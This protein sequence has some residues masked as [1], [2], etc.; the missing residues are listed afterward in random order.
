MIIVNG[1]YVSKIVCDEIKSQQELST[2]KTLHVDRDVSCF[3]RELIT[4]DDVRKIIQKIRTVISQNFGGELALFNLSHILQSY[5]LQRKFGDYEQQDL[6]D[7]F[8]L[9]RGLGGDIIVEGYVARIHAQK[10]GPRAMQKHV[11]ML[12]MSSVYAS[13]NKTLFMDYNT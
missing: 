2:L 13:R 8:R 5:F 4:K 1:L 3:V 12:R 6:D 10:D 7:L 11:E 9:L